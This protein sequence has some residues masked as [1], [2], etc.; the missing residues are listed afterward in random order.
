MSDIIVEKPYKTTVQRQR[1]P[2]YPGIGLAKCVELVKKVYDNAHRGEV[3]SA[4]LAKLLGYSAG[5]GQALTAASAIKKFALMEGRGDGHKVSE[6][7]LKI[8]EPMNPEE[9]RDAI[10][11]AA[12]KPELYTEVMTRFGGKIPS[13]E[14]IRSFLIRQYKFAPI[15]ADNFIKAF[16]ET[17][18][19]VERY[20]SS[21]EAPQNN[22]PSE[23]SIETPRNTG[24]AEVDPRIV[25]TETLPTGERLTF[26][27]S[28]SAKVHVIFEGEITSAAIEK[29]I[30]CLELS[31]DSYEPTGVNEWD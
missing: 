29:L 12:R 1:S 15:G 17:I 14:V 22:Q 8:L 26:R 6:L 5:S 30:K 4:T 27:I 2:G 31:K 7:A 10:N 23:E 24:S 20:P 3:D 28:S 19:L 13:D 11:E 9:R 21:N 18:E 25:Q 16:R